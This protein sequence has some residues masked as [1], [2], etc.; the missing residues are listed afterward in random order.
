MDAAAVPALGRPPLRGSSSPRPPARYTSQ[1]LRAGA[2][3]AGHWG[4]P[5]RGARTGRKSSHQGTA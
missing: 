1:P 3:A 5:T 2:A 4:S